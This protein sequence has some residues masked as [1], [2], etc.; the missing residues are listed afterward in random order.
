[1]YASKSLHL[2]AKF[3]NSFRIIKHPPVFT[4]EEANICMKDVVEGKS[5]NLFLRNKK[6]NTHYLVCVSDD[7]RGDL[8]ELT[9]ILDP[10]NLS[11]ASPERLMKYLWVTPRSVTP[12]WFITDSQSEVICIFDEKLF[13]HELVYFHPNRNDVT[14]ELKTS[15]FLKYCKNLGNKIE[16]LNI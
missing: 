13:S 4:C 8:K 9:I 6:W 16:I 14:L 3:M 15:D 11:F 7:N 2:S 12:F 1:M 10:S 5:K